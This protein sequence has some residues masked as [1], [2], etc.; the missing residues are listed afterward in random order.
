MQIAS[1]NH[2]EIKDEI[3]NKI[4]LLKKKYEPKQ[5]EKASNIFKCKVINKL[6]IKGDVKLAL[7]KLITKQRKEPLREYLQKW[8]IFTISEPFY[9]QNFSINN[10][11]IKLLASISTKDQVIRKCPNKSILVLE[12]N[13]TLL[14]KGEI[15]DKQRTDTSINQHLASNANN[16]YFDYLV[17]NKLKRK[18]KKKSS[19]NSKS[20]NGNKVKQDKKKLGKVNIFLIYFIDKQMC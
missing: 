9:D 17:I 1:Q 12:S 6:I 16:I 14:S 15:K 8:K 11:E 19:K 3:F 4:M 7:A 18:R 5:L 10:Y 2:Y 13:S 20:Q